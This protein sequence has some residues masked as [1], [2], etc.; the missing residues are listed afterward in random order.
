MKLLPSPIFI[1]SELK[2]KI[3]NIYADTNLFLW[4]MWPKLHTFDINSATFFKI[5][6]E[7]NLN[8]PPLARQ[9]GL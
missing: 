8:I 2:L 9:N 5:F 3:F 4:K 6:I 1:K 7:K